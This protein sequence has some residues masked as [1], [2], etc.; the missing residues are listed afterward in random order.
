MLCEQTPDSLR[1]IR[2][3]FAQTVRS[4][5][6]IDGRL[7]PIRHLLQFIDQNLN[8]LGRVLER[9]HQVPQL[10]EGGYAYVFAVA[11]EEALHR[12]IVGTVSFIREARSCFENL[13]DFRSEF[14][15]QYVERPVEN[16]LAR[17]EALNKILGKPK[18]VDDLR[19]LRHELSHDRYPWLAFRVRSRKRPKYEP[20]LV[21][22]WRPGAVGNAADIAS[23]L[24]RPS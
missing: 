24:A 19:D 9:D 15:T 12:A 10:I 1:S 4:A 20:V 11:D 17:Y 16:K 5:F 3:V 21:L 8:Q 18:W 22:D 13:A 7:H 14:L 23:C 6:A 2:L